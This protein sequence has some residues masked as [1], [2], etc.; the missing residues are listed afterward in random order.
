MVH[1]LLIAVASLVER[2]LW[3]PQAS[4]AVA[5]RLSSCGLQALE[6]MLSSCGARASV[7]VAHRLSSCGSRALEHRLSSCGARA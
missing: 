3:A 6:H 5:R 1:G 4:V 2:G 7:V